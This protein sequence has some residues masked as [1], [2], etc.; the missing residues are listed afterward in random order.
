[1]AETLVV[2]DVLR[3]IKELTSDLETMRAG[4]SRQVFEPGKSLTSN[5]TLGV[6]AGSE[7]ISQFQ[8]AVDDLRHV[9]W[10]LAETAEFTSKAD[11][12]SQSK[13]L[14]RATEILCALS[15]HPPLPK[16]DSAPCADSFV[17]R[18]LQLM[19]VPADPKTEAG[20]STGEI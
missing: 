2:E 17:A 14:R 12:A 15:L 3:R 13:L 18:L 8:E 10:L 9:L 19:E 6:A 4:I 11:S 16:L 7:I 1:M 5:R 20:S